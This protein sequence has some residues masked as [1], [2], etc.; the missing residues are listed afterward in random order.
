MRGVFVSK[1]RISIL[2]L[3]N[4]R[5]RRFFDRMAYQI[6]EYYLMH[7]NIK[8]AKF[9]MSEFGT[10]INIIEIYNKK[11][12]PY[13]T[14]VSE[15]DINEKFTEWKNG[16]RIPIER[17]Y[18]MQI[19]KKTRKTVPELEIL[20]LGLGMCDCYWFQPADRNY[21]WEDIN[22]YDNGFGTEIGR[23]LINATNN[24]PK[25]LKTPNTI[26]PG[27]C[28]K[29][30]ARFN[31]TNYLVKGCRTYN[32]KKTEI[33]NEVFA[34]LMASKLGINTA[35]YYLLRSNGVT[36]FCC[37][38]NFISNSS[39]DFV[40]FEQLAKEPNTFGKNGVLRFLKEHNLQNYLNQ[41]IIIDYL[42]G[43]YNRTLDDIGFLVNADTM[44]FVTT[45]P[46]FDYEE[47]INTNMS[48]EDISGIFNEDITKQVEMV[49]DFSWI[50]FDMIKESI[51]ELKRIFCACGFKKEE[52]DVLK[53]YL[54]KRADSLQKMVPPGQLMKT[55]K[56]IKK[57]PKPTKSKIEVPEDSVIK[58]HL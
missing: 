28:P 47:S 30:W 57:K 19:Y 56:K 21:K 3:Q 6:D 24:T 32:G 31:N 7:K 14:H 33:C 36:D 10:K 8:V 29:M 51:E 54:L 5:G 52:T 53:E 46:I 15:R 18:L 35:E 11:H 20:N 38:P 42:I 45:A 58:I 23:M 50:D 41:L 44:E 49:S 48:D 17:P 22:F 12:M 9:S 34:S 1:Y 26:L 40:T 55:T 4:I 2:I 39:T 16:R 43:N 25:S 27:E 37:T 13:G